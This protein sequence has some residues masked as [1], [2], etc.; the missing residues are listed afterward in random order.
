MKM[1]CKLV[2]GF[3]AAIVLIALVANV[4]LDWASSISMPAIS[5]P[6][7]HWKEVWSNLDSCLILIVM[8]ILCVEG[9]KGGA[10]IFTPVIGL[11][12]LVWI[13]AMA[14]IL[15]TGHNC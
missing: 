5:M 7:L 14:R 4:C 12:W 9:R 11:L 13:V 2:L 10:G 1:I 8:T 6:T 15:L 3:L